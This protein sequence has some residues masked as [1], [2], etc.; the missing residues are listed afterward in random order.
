MKVRVSHELPMGHRL[1]DHNGLCRFPH[2]HN[3]Q[4]I[5]ELEGPVN[6]HSGMV[7][8]F[9]D[10]KEVVKRVLEP[11]DHGFVISHDDTTM[12]EALKYAP[13]LTTRLHIISS[14]PTAE[15]LSV[16]WLKMIKHELTMRHLDYNGVKVTVYETSKSSVTAS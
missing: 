14:P 3:Y 4:V 9:H 13:E 1:K 10:L 8:D 7:I 5:V 6:D 15:V 12:L 16:V 11:F 2:G